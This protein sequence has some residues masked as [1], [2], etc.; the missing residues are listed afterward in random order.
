MLQVAF[1]ILKKGAEDSEISQLVQLE[2][3]SLF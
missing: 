1:Q 2:T 3:L